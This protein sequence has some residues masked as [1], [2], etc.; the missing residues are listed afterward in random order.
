MKVKKIKKIII[1][2]FALLL[3]V[4]ATFIYYGVYR[5][6]DNNVKTL[7]YGLGSNGWGPLHPA[8]QSSLYGAIIISHVFDSL[9]GVDDT[10]GFIPSLAKAWDISEDRRIYTFVLDTQRTFSD[11]T[12]LTAQIYK[13]SLLNSL[14]MEAAITNK[15]ALDV[16]YALVGYDDY[17][18]T[19]D[20]PG[21][22]VEGDEKLIMYFKKPYRRAIDQLSGTRYGAYIE[23][24]GHYIGTGPY[25]YQHIDEDLVEL[26]P[27]PHY[28][29]EVYVEKVRITGAG[30]DDLY[31]GNVSLSLGLPMVDIHDESHKDIESEILSSLLLIHW[32]VVLNGLKPSLLS[33]IRMRQAVQYII[34]RSFVDD[35]KNYTRK[36]FFTPTIQFYPPLTPGHIDKDEAISL[37]AEGEKYIEELVRATLDKPL[38]CVSRMRDSENN[39]NYCD[40]LQKAGVNIS[41]IEADFKATKDI[42]YRNHDADMVEYGISYA[43]ADPD[44][45]YH[46]LGR[47][48][49][50]WTPMSSRPNIEQM[51]EDGRSLLERHDLNEHYKDVSRTIIKE[52]PM[53]H[54][55]FQ[56]LFLRYNSRLLKPSR[57][58]SA[59]RKAINA[60]LFKWR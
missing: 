58:V 6:N 3:A 46:Y 53:V 22:V 47:N 26:L 24:N 56:N 52:V 20:I 13:Q 37:M 32:G 57:A 1:I 19:G 7:N 48:G 43:S 54:L 35:E 42:I 41:V 28:P 11:G 23:K 9:V 45:I 60:V 44:G 5:M 16:L 18:S 10:G 33:D 15:S 25:V 2:A 8:Q 34:Y 38:K 51:L 36:P 49:A 27:N 59:R 14:K 55:G 40:V 50:I 39:Y 12:K 21:L 31:R 29:F 17:V 4:A 30:S